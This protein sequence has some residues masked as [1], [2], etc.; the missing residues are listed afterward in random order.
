M[1]GKALHECASVGG[2]FGGATYAIHV[3][4]LPSWGVCLEPCQSCRC[5]GAL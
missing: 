5:P 1:L 2:S 3:G 4:T